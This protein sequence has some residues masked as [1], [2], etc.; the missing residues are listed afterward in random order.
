MRPKILEYFSQHDMAIYVPDYKTLYIAMISIAMILSTILAMRRGLP[1]FKFY[2]ATASICIIAV[3]SSRVCFVLQNFELT[4]ADDFLE[5]LF[6]GGT[7]SYGAYLG[8]FIGGF[9]VLKSMKIKILP[10]LDIYA[11]IMALCL[12]IGRLGCFLSGCCFGKPSLLPWAVSFPP[13]SPAHSAQSAADMIRNDATNSLPVHPTQIYEAL[14]G[15]ILFA[16]L[17]GLRRKNSTDGLF[18]FTYIASYA[19]FRFFIEFVRGDDRG[20]LIG[21]SMPQ[22]F[23]ILLFIL[24][25]LGFAYV[26]QRKVR[27][28]HKFR[29][30]NL[31]FISQ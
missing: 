27:I 1:M 2:L 11:P 5:G 25:F 6:R 7:V 12:G 19:A 9:I 4:L 8:G 30:I 13:G 10:A 20:L 14:F 29:L 31:G 15:V 26:R 16:L 3:L 18:F 23:S 17:L 24:G 21:L 28:L 22:V